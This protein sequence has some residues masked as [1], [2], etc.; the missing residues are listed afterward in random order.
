[1]TIGQVHALDDLMAPPTHEGRAA[2]VDAAGL[3]DAV[4]IDWLLEQAEEQLHL[5][6]ATAEAAL[7]LVVERAAEMDLAIVEGQAHYLHARIL[8]ERGDL[9]AAVTSIANARGRF[10]A[11]GATLQAARTELGRMQ[12]LDDLGRHAEALDVGEA[13]LETLPTMATDG[14]DDDRMRALIT[15]AAWG[16]CGVAC[17]YL[18][19]HHRSLAAYERAEDGYASLGML[20]ESAQWQANRGVELLSLGSAEEAA[21]ALAKAASGFESAGDRLWSAKCQGDL[22]QAD[23]LRGNLIGALARLDHAHEVLDTLGADAETARIKLQLGQTYLDAGLWRESTVASA[24]AAEIATRA[25]MLHDQ[26]HAHLLAARAAVAGGAFSEAEHELDTA[27]GLF[28]EVGDAQFAARSNL[29]AAELLLRRGFTEEGQEL[30]EA[31]VEVLMAGGWKLPASHAML[32]LHD[33]A[34]EPDT[35]AGWLAF[36]DEIAD[37]IGHPHLTTAVRLRQA[38]ALRARGKLEPATQLLSAAI[39][40]LEE[41]G[42]ALS[43]PLLASA[44]SVSK[45]PA[46]DELV[47]LLASRGTPESLAEA[48]ALSDRAK[49]Q[50]L[51]DLVGG[52][53]GRDGSPAQQLRSDRDV[54]V[55]SYRRRLSAVYAAIH[56][57]TDPQRIAPLRD[58]A[59][60]LE[61]QLGDLLIRHHS[62]GLHVVTDN[63]RDAAASAQVHVRRPGVAFHVA[64]ADIVA[65]TVDGTTVS[66]TILRGAYD[67]ARVLVDQLS[68]QWGRFRMGLHFDLSQHEARLTATT[69]AILAEL[70]DVLVRPLDLPVADGGNLVVSPDR[71]LHRIPFQALHDGDAYLLERFPIV[72]SPTTL[73]LS[74]TAPATSQ[75][76]LVVGVPDDRAPSIASEV[77]L[78]ASADPDTTVLLG[79]D[80]TVAAVVE[81]SAGATHVHLACHGMYREENP[82][83]SSL[84]FADRWSTVSEVLELDLN[85]KAVT[86]SAC[87]SGRADDSADPVGMAWGFLAAGADSVVVSQWVLDDEVSSEVMAT[88]HARLRAGRPAEQALR[89]AQ[90][91]VLQHRPHPYYWAPFVYVAS[92]FSAVPETRTS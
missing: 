23:H 41:L 72:M 57:S 40:K 4:G 25:G 19:L 7:V 88:Y 89:E 11:A 71:L 49:A 58:R 82:L 42:S 10:Q 87:E 38:Q 14:P 64:G 74:K 15:A 73:S 55:A 48:V 6:P 69:R 84:R 17:G 92:P 8:A 54:E 22:A 81:A 77:E 68:A 63:E 67:R 61:A 27:R 3:T 80:A 70:Y 9:E 47:H 12:I 32:A 78:I 36:A 37:E 56:E 43:E 52:T 44:F 51:A 46:Y 29:V 59:R 21:E 91:A 24:E 34:V 85:G 28:G 30:L 20:L 13:L 16:N 79:D 26:A 90:L 65:F 62:S 33:A 86:L 31:T 53:I 39:D 76:L 75:R 83:F 2:L 45:R 66:G 35:K 18:G 1:M 60:E 50:T 5:A